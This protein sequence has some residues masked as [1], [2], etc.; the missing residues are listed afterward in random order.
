MKIDLSLNT[1]KYNNRQTIMI[2]LL[3]LLVLALILTPIFLIVDYRINYLEKNKENLENID[4]Q[5]MEIEDKQMEVSRKLRDLNMVDKRYNKKFISVNLYLMA[6]AIDNNIVFNNIEY[7][8]NNVSII[9]ESF[10]KESI[11]NII[12]KLNDSVII[13]HLNLDNFQKSNQKYSFNINYQI[14]QNIRGNEE[15]EYNEFIQ[16]IQN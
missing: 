7:E 8:N 11:F 14:K 5:L 16:K 9:G 1:K 13:E 4:M 12:T 2:G 10:N 6:H 15:E 3:A